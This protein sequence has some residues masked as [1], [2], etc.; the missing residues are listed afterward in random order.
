MLSIAGVI[1]ASLFVGSSVAS[2]KRARRYYWPICSPDYWWYDYADVGGNG[3]CHARYRFVFTYADKAIGR[4]AG[5]TIGW[6]YCGFG[7]WLSHLKP[8]SPP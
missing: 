7:Y 4:W 2:P 5:Y 1:G 6:L 8:T 3:G